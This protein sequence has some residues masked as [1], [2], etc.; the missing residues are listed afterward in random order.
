MVSGG[1]PQRDTQA[2]PSLGNDDRATKL[3]TRML[4][5]NISEIKPELDFTSEMGFTYPLIEETQNIRGQEAVAFLESLVSNGI[6]NKDFFDRFLNCP[7]CRSVNLR[8]TTHC[9]KCASGNI[10]RG[11][12]L[13]HSIC[14][15]VGLEEEFVSQGRLI[16]PKCKAELKKLE[17]DYR[18]LGLMRKCH[19][20]GDVFPIPVLKW[21]C[22]RCSSITSEDKVVEVNIYSYSLDEAK[23]SW[24]EFELKPK[25]RLTEFLKQRG[26]EVSANATKRG[27][28]GAEHSFYKAYDTGIHEKVL[29]V[30]PPLDEEATAFASHQRIKVLPL[31]ELEST[32]AIATPPPKEAVETQPFVLKSIPQLVEHLKKHGYEVK[33]NAAVR[34]RSDAEHKI[35]VLATRNEGIFNHQIAIGIEVSDETLELDKVFDFDVKA[36]DIGIQ[37]KVLIASPGLSPPAKQFAERQR[38]K[39]FEVE[40]LDSSG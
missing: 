17:S 28:P 40:K 21:R 23:R 35:D 8:P 36:Y 31:A 7:Q 25:A 6:L 34:G 11:R 14:G 9:P 18:S 32:L 33:E 38:I 5:G 16:C 22:L 19:A 2:M 29:L 24:L 30:D 13:E 4:E 27:R 39:V 10:A 15:Y 37:D 12:V 3:V 1:D 26:Y 20:C